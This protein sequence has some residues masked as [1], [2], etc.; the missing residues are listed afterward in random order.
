[1]LVRVHAIGLVNIVAGKK[2]VPELIQQN[3]TVQKIVATAEGLLNNDAARDAMRKDLSLVKGLLGS[4]G[5]SANVANAV[6]AMRAA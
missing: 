4:K 6:L 5:A 2:I 1:M 3:A